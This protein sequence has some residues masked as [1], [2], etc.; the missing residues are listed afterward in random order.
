MALTPAEPI[1]EVVW[2]LGRRDAEPTPIAPR[3]PDLEGASIAF[4]WDHVFRGDDMFARFGE[5]AAQRYDDITLVGHD[6]FGNIHG[7]LEEHDVV[8]GLA[9]RLRAENADAAVV[10]VGA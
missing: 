5:A 6:A 4:V 10:G 3:L 8:E 7:I 2:P 1:Y 9:D